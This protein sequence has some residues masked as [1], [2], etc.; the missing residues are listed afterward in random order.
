MDVKDGL[1]L[2]QDRC[3]EAFANRAYP[4]VA[5]SKPELLG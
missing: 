1:E 4:V 3:M 5:L 2:L